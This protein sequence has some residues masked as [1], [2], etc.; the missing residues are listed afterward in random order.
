MF[1][2]SKEKKKVAYLHNG[3][4]HNNGKEQW[5]MNGP[6]W[7]EARCIRAY[8]LAFHLCK[9]QRSEKVIVGNRSQRLKG[10]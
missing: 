4:L 8:I 1:I 10:Y 7:I 9:V 2:N 5:L 3:I 6:A